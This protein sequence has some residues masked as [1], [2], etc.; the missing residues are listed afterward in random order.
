MCALIDR[1]GQKLRKKDYTSYTEFYNVPICSQTQSL[2]I[3]DRGLNTGTFFFIW[4]L[5]KTRVG[6]HDPKYLRN[7]KYE[8][9]RK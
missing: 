1:F 2:L 5:R 4:G 8:L 6:G 9:H 3:K 7:T